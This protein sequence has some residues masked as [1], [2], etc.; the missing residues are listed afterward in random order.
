M[1]RRARIALIGATA[2]VAMLAVTWWVSRHVAP[3]R[4]ADGSMLSGFEALQRPGVN[5]L[6]NF[7]AALCDP[8]QYVFLA[9]V[10]VLM[11]LL[12]RRAWL[13][14]VVLLVIFAANETTQLLKPLLAAPR[15][16]V[17]GGPSTDASWP[18]GHA[19]AAMSLALCCVIAAPP[20]WRSWVA[21]VMAAFTVAVCWSFLELGWHYPSDVFGGFL[22]ATAWALVAVAVVWTAQERA[23]RRAGEGAG[24]GSRPDRCDDPSA[25]RRRDPSG[26]LRADLSVAQAVTPSLALTA[27][28]L[29]FAMLV[30]ALRPDLVIGY[31]LDHETFVAGAAAIGTLALTIATGLS[32]ILQRT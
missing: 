16:P 24:A 9:M 7:I 10:P 20:R 3:F 18:S 2:A 15:V 14:V 6:T 30:L 26:A 29:A 32:L 19:T 22:V 21:A 4:A 27:A 17:P 5:G 11:A 28:A 31:A 1:P 25:L 13:A 12:R 8:Q 23:T